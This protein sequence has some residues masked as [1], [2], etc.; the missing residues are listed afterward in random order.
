MPWESKTIKIWSLGDLRGSFLYFSWSKCS[1]S[2][3][4]VCLTTL[5]YSI[6]RC[7]KH[8]PKNL[9]VFGLCVFRQVAAVHHVHH[10]VTSLDPSAAADPVL[11]V[12]TSALAVHRA[13]NGGFKRRLFVPE[14]KPTGPG[15]L[16]GPGREV[17]ETCAWVGGRELLVLFGELPRCEW[18]RPV[19]DRF[20]ESR[21][22]T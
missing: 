16:P 6:H 13:S 18:P 8:G 14:P 20:S 21:K 11:H 4:R 3:S 1:L 15:S 5:H 22:A 17:R 12:C 10:G 19:G 9:C 7:L 2:T